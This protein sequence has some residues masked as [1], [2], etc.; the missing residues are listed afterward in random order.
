MQ[1]PDRAPGDWTNLGDQAGRY[2]AIAGAIHFFGGRTVLDVGC[3]VAH[4]ANYLPRCVYRGIDCSGEAIGLARRRHPSLNLAVADI[5]TVD[6][7][8]D[9]YD[10]IVFNEVLYYL[11][12]PIRVIE[13]AQSALTGSGIII[14]SVYQKPGRWLWPSRNQRCEARIRLWM[15]ANGWDSLWDQDVVQG[16]VIW[17]VFTM[18]ATRRPQA[19][20][21]GHTVLTEGCG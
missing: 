20:R 16:N 7:P 8:T 15:D 6:L 5:T 14:C 3:G 17:H 1:E 9:A 11:S 19:A 10:V 2:R 4:L 21:H 18:R 12:D 13:R